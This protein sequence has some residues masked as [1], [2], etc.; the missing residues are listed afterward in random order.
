MLELN[1]R[2]WWATAEELQTR[3]SATG[4]TTG[5]RRCCCNKGCAGD[6]GGSERASQ[7]ARHDVG[8]RV[9]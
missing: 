8:L 4:R 9:L 2:A 7:R 5:K 3:T 6:D 1:T